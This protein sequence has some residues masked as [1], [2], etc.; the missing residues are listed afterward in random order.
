MALVEA[1][2]EEETKANVPV[3][4]LHIS[5]LSILGALPFVRILAYMAASSLVEDLSSPGSVQ[6]HV[7][8]RPKDSDQSP[9][10][11]VG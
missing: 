10:K 5:R 3:D 4:L 2:A 11:E 1:K 9:R 8:R 6:G 7:Y